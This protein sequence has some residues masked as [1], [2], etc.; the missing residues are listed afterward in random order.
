MLGEM[1]DKGRKNREG[2]GKE[3][4]KRR[5]ERGERVYEMKENID[6]Q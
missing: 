4:Y 6:K 5:R 3:N 1:K 2:L